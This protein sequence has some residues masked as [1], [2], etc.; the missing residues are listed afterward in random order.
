MDIELRHEPSFQKYDEQTLNAKFQLKRKQKNVIHLQTHGYTYKQN[1]RLI[2]TR[3]KKTE[4]V[5]LFDEI[6][7]CPFSSSIS[8]LITI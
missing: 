7:D 8:L 4:K 1:N 6:D 3:K 5:Q 2:L